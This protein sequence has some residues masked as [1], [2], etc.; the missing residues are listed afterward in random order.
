MSLATKLNNATAK[1]VRRI[2]YYL[3]Y[4]YERNGEIY[5]TEK[6]MEQCRKDK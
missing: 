2:I 6:R 3:P 1:A 4:F 5:E